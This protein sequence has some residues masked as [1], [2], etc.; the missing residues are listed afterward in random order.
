MLHFME[1]YEFLDPNRS[2]GFVFFN[3]EPFP[4]I[5]PVLFIPMRALWRLPPSHCSHSAFLSKESA[6]PRFF[7]PTQFQI[8]ICLYYIDGLLGTE[9]GLPYSYI[10]QLQMQW[11]TNMYGTNLSISDLHPSLGSA[12]LGEVGDY[13]CDIMEFPSVRHTLCAFISRHL[14][15]PL[16]HLP[17]PLADSSAAASGFTSYIKDFSAV[18]SNFSASFICCDPGENNFCQLI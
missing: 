9:L 13:R 8:H 16:F 11:V 18:F 14:M 2:T 7:S 4:E 12:A 6:F 17:I 1:N 5:N 15:P 10:P 3:P